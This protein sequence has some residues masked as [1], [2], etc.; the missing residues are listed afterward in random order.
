M[1][2]DY[3]FYVLVSIIGVSRKHN[4]NLA[5]DLTPSPSFPFLG[6][7][8]GDDDV[9][10]GD[11]EVWGQCMV[12]VARWCGDVGCVVFGGGWWCV[13]CSV[14]LFASYGIFGVVRGGGYGLG[15]LFFLSGYP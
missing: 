7:V 15:F 3:T 11:D 4:R 10:M 6:V 8:W 12:L 9:G 13:G 5:L 1:Q 14:V 2:N